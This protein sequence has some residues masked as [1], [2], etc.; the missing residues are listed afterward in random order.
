M[1]ASSYYF[2]NSTEESTTVKNTEVIN[3]FKMITVCFK[4]YVEENNV[5]F[6]CL[7]FEIEIYLFV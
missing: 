1:N 4:V 7:F 3:R 6:I 5:L 2:F